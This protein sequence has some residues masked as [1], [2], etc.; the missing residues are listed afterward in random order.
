MYVHF[1]QESL[2]GANRGMFLMGASETCAKKNILKLNQAGVEEKNQS[3]RHKQNLKFEISIWGKKRQKI[4]ARAT[5]DNLF[6][7]GTT[8]SCG[9]ESSLCW[10]ESAMKKTSLRYENIGKLTFGVSLLVKKL[11]IHSF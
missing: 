1:F 6:F 11:K 7:P 5:A 8:K 4:R 2:I 3:L 10:L 9:N